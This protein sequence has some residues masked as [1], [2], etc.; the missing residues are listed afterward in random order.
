MNINAIEDP[1]PE[2]FL[3]RFKGRI[4]W[5]ETEQDSMYMNPAG[6][7]GFVV[8]YRIAQ[9]L[10]WDREAKAGEAISCVCLN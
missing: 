8:T 9:V 4:A 10:L 1:R 6:K 2:L 5:Y 3:T 7:I